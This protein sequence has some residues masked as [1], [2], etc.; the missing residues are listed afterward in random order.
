[1]VSSRTIKKMATGLSK[2]LIKKY[3]W[4]AG[5]IISDGAGAN[6][7]TSKDSSNMTENLF[8]GYL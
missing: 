3:M 5:K 2:K 6:S 8:K 1:M 7:T 4:D